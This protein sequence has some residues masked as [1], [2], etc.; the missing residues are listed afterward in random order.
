MLALACVLLQSLGAG[1]G[2]DDGA[3]SPPLVA[4]PFL[5][6]VPLE[7]DTRTRLP[8]PAETIAPSDRP[9]FYWYH[10][11][12]PG[13]TITWEVRA[14]TTALEHGTVIHTEG[15]AVPEGAANAQGVVRIDPKRLNRG[16]ARRNQAGRL[17]WLPGIYSIK[18]RFGDAE[19]FGTGIFE[20]AR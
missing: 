3:S 9:R 8:A 18:G 16:G 13:R 2:D 12:A 7:P 1:C 20:V 6:E 19:P 10:A 17:E 11:E 5:G 14:E 15:Q 4:G